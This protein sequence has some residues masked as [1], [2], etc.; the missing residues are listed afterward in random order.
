MR[1][2]I[3]AFTQPGL[4]LAKKAAQ[5]T[6]GTVEIY[7]HER[8]MDTV[9]SIDKAGGTDSAYR[10]DS[11]ERTDGVI[12][13]FHAVGKVIKEQFYQCDRILFIGAAAIA[14]RVIAP[15]L[16][17]K[18]TDPAVLV[19]DEDGKFLISLLSGHIGGANEWCSTLAERLGA[20]PVI[21]T[22]TDTRG[23][24]AVD[25]FAGKHRLR[26]CKSCND[27]GHF[28]AHFKS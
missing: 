13:S 23:M 14:V 26:H 2:I 25:L 21:T 8:C 24:F 6:E 20:A 11:S 27:S 10:A 1:T 28:G 5:N 18:T 12:H 17:S 4:Q 22:A 3:I 19:A 16:K 15:Y 7:G 9:N